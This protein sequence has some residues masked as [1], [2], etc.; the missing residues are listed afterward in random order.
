MNMNELLADVVVKKEPFTLE[1]YQEEDIS[2]K[3]P[4]NL[5]GVEAINRFDLLL[6][7]IVMIDKGINAKA[8]N[9]VSN[10]DNEYESFIVNIKDIPFIAEMVPYL[11]QLSSLENVDEKY[12]WFL[13]GYRIDL[14]LGLKSVVFLNS[15]ID[16]EY[17]GSKEELT[18]TYENSY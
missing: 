2:E 1:E 13:L 16:I 7:E 6:E 3:V 8:V 14:V 11:I 12:I 17:V 5:E 4:L 15:T 10:V 9:L 18:F